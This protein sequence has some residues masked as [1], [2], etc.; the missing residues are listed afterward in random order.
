MRAPAGRHPL[1]AMPG[2]LPRL[3]RRMKA[4]A[5]HRMRARRA[6][7]GGCATGDGDHIRCSRRGV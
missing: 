2:V 7:A 4:C 5:R 3:R 1:V 6:S